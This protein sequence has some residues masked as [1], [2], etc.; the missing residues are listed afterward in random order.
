MG[1]AKFDEDIRDAI[2]DRQFLKQSPQKHKET[3]ETNV[4]NTRQHRN[5]AL[6]GT[7]EH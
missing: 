3:Q 4:E 5:D 7:K 2:D 6:S 1:W